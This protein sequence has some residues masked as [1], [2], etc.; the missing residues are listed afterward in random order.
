MLVLMLFY[1]STPVCITDSRYWT[2]LNDVLACEDA[3]ATKV[4]LTPI[5]ARRSILPLLPALI[6][7]IQAL[8]SQAIEAAHS[9]FRLCLP[10]SLLKA[11]DDFV[12]NC[13]WA[14]LESITSSGEDISSCSPGSILWTLG[15][16]TFRSRFGSLKDKAKVSFASFPV[17]RVPTRNSVLQVHTMFLSSKLPS[18]TLALRKSAQVPSLEALLYAAGEDILLNSQEALGSIIKPP[19]TDPSSSKSSQSDFFHVISNTVHQHN[20]D[21]AGLLLPLLPR[22]FRSFI[23]AVPKFSLD[24]GEGLSK[25][26]AADNRVKLAATMFLASASRTLFR[27]VSAD[28]PTELDRHLLKARVQ[29]LEILESESLLTSLE[30]AGVTLRAEVD[31]AREV[32]S[33]G[34]R[35]LLYI[36]L[37]CLTTIISCRYSSERRTTNPHTPSQV[38]LRSR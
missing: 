7:H 12:Q 24:V 9:I 32:I 2:L 31:F 28:V 13:F 27:V 17:L 20:G 6:R 18:W 14:V 38:R 34:A 19:P 5:L 22:L 21:G 26:L 35:L 16:E 11:N 1:C 15:L 29:V 4:W 36:L 10:A 37:L 3:K 33:N 30:E 25:Q 23:S 8:D